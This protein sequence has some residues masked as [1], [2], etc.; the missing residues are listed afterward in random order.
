M[1]KKYG[2]VCAFFLLAFSARA[3]AAEAPG[4][5]VVSDAY[6]GSKWTAAK[7]RVLALREDGKER[8]VLPAN[9]DVEGKGKYARH[10]SP[11]GKRWLQV[12][13]IEGISV[14]SIRN[15]LYVGA[16][17]E[18]LQ[19]K[20]PLLENTQIDEAQ[21]MPDGSILLSSGIADW[22]QGIEEFSFSVI[23]S[24]TGFTI[25]NFAPQRKRLYATPRYETNAAVSANG[26]QLVFVARSAAFG[27]DASE[28]S[29][30]R[31]SYLVSMPLKQG[32]A[33][34]V[35][36]FAA[37]IGRPLWNAAGDSCV[38]SASNGFDGEGK[39]LVSN[40]YLYR[41]KYESI[42]QLTFSRFQND[43]PCW[44]HDGK[45]IVW[46]SNRPLPKQQGNKR[47]LYIMN[48]D[49]TGQKIFAADVNATEIAWRAQKP[50]P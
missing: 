24:T 33:R 10:I 31:N 28:Y 49:G 44:S 3:F 36:A 6:G 32:Q 41:K 23:D 8:F 42:L 27:S 2:R 26:A 35:A 9:S 14:R 7:T 45:R 20:K 15:A 47:R 1:R 25:Q 40:I 37:N 30:D 29:P 34:L 21:W 13:F 19:G 17:G 48:A 18:T 16:I 5:I 4:W 22:E 12:A 50:A 46:L 11:D 38:F 43:L 39:A